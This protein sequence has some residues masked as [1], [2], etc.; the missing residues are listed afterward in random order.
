[1]ACFSLFEVAPREAIQKQFDVNVFGVLDVIRAIL[2][3]FRANRSGTIIN[4]SSGAGVFGAAMA[5]V[6]SASKFALEGF[7]EALSYELADLGINVKIIEPGGISSTGF[8]AR[9]RTETQTLAQPEDYKA[10]LAHISEVYGSMA[11]KAETDALNKVAQAIFDAATDET[12]QLRYLPT[13]NIR[14]LV[15]A[16]RETSEKDYMAL[17][18]GIFLPRP[19]TNGYETES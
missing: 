12:D 1:M 7:S 9:A 4:V 16:R 18:L 17:T 10:F 15:T 11:A 6:Y 13:E 8:M 14:P 3:H 5:S 19:V 2:P